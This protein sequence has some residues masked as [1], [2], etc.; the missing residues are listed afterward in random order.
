LSAVSLRAGAAVLAIGGAALALAPSAHGAARPTDLRVSKTAGIPTQSPPGVNYTIKTTVTNKGTRTAKSPRVFLSLVREGQRTPTV[1]RVGNRTLP[2][3]LRAGASQ[4][5]SVTL[6]INAQRRGVYRVLV[7]ATQASRKYR[8][9]ISP[10]LKIVLPAAAP[11]TPATP[12]TPADT[13]PMDV[14]LR[15]AISPEALKQHMDAFAAIGARNGNRAAGTQGYDDSALYVINR[16][17]KADYEVSIDRFEFVLFSEQAPPQFTSSAGSWATPADYVTMSYSGSGDTGA[18]TPIQAVDL[19][20]TPTPDNAPASSNTSGCEDAD[21]VG[22][23]AGNIA[24]MKRGTCSFAE[25]AQNAVEAGASGVIIFNEGQPGRE[26]TLNGTLG[27]PLQGGADVPV[28]GTSA[29]VG[30]ALAAASNPTGRLITQTTNEPG[31]SYNVLADTPG[32]DPDKTV[33]VGAHLDSVEESWGISDNATGSAFNLELAEQYA[34]LGITPKNRVRFAWWGAEES[35]LIGS[36]QYVAGLSDEEFE[37][38][39]LNLNYDMIGSPNF[40]R[41]VYDGD[42]SDTPKPAATTLAPGSADVEQ[43]FK[44][45]F[46]SAGLATQPSAFDGRSDYKPFQDNGIPA[47]GLFT[48]AESIKSEEQQKLFGG[49]AG[50]AFDPNYHAAGDDGDNYSLTAL[51][52]MSDAGATVSYNYSQ[53]DQLPR[54]FGQPARSAG[55]RGPRSGSGG[56]RR[57]DRFVR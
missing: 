3:P 50:V 46:D 1:P 48:G 39:G 55:S 34:A 11:A 14:R 38:I 19:G 18:N 7:C 41:F 10:G 43:A 16:L 30:E 37:R 57:G 32:G 28:I 27:G 24:L 51:E 40:A 54:K 12:A 42:F 13:R 23:T 47:G 2:R 8:C 31:S 15:E 22:F 4:R 29:A 45:Y 33:V 21:F 20:T 49:I 17:A 53:A 9:N 26:A 5:V 25:K 36:T 44:A 56:E 52:Q 6:R 35:G